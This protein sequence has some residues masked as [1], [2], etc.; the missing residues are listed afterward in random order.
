M[1]YRSNL[2]WIPA[3]YVGVRFNSSSGVDKSH[4]ISPQ[5]VYAGTWTQIYLYP[6]K[7]QNAVYSQD[8]TAGE[9]KSADGITITT[10]DTANTIFDIS[11]LYRIDPNVMCTSKEGKEQSSVFQVLDEFGVKPIETIQAQYIRRIVRDQANVVGNLYDIYSLMG[12]KRAEASEMLTKK[13]AEVLGPKGIT[14]LHAFYLRA[15]P[16]TSLTAKISNNVNS[17]TQIQIAG[18]NQQ[19]AAKQAQINIVNEQSKQTA[20]KLA[21]A[22]TGAKS[23]EIID[24]ELA[25]KA[26]E[27]WHG[28]LPTVQGGGKSTVIV[29]ASGSSV[30]PVE[31]KDGEK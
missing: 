31:S 6:T 25:Q 30:T 18:L 15:Y 20:Q 22:G 16:N 13:L 2:T 21:G 10:K 3:G 24:L 7:I 17:V 12:P 1:Y 23:L 4:V 19:I 11:V 28:H 27:K 8:P 26:A 14:V 5:A 29:N 9:V